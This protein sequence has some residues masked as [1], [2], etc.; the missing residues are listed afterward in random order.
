MEFVHEGARYSLDA[1]AVR[2]ALRGGA[3]DDVRTHWV[4]VDGTRWPPKQVLALATGLD[5]SQPRPLRAPATH[6]AAAADSGLDQPAQQGGPHPE[7]LTRSCL[8]RIAVAGETG[9]AEQ[10]GHGDLG[11]QRVGVLQLAFSFLEEL[12]AGGT[13]CGGPAMPAR[14]GFG[15]VRPLVFGL[16]SP[17]FQRLCGPRR[18]RAMEACVDHGGPRP[19]SAGGCGPSAAVAWRRLASGGAGRAAAVAHRRRHPT[20]GG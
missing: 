5:R 20:H 10:S 6:P 17:A 11:G 13:G 18:G 4:D 19:S 9:G 14:L 12:N 15:G 1:E 16:T 7:Q 2:S 3:P 8:S